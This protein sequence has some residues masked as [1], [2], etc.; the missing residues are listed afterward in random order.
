ME[1]DITVLEEEKIVLK[2]TE[3]MKEAL[4]IM[5]KGHGEVQRHLCERSTQYWTDLRAP[6]ERSDESVGS[7]Q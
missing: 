3:S 6:Q 5:E 2:Q 7:R 4:R 1:C